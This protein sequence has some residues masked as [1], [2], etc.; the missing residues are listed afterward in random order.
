M[1]QVICLT[2]HRPGAGDLGA[3]VHHAGKA[4]GLFGA[5]RAQM[6]LNKPLNLQ[7]QPQRVQPGGISGDIP[8]G[9]KP[10]SAAARLTGRKIEN[11]AQLLR[12][13][14]RVALQGGEYSDINPIQHVRRFLKISLQY[15]EN[16]HLNPVYTKTMRRNSVE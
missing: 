2:C 12:R 5:M 10:L 13:Q 4:C 3:G 6:H 9:L 14:M 1:K 8:L 15:A 7:T 16:T 11:V